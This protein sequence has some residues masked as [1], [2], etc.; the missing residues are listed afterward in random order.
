MNPKANRV[1]PCTYAVKSYLKKARQR[2]PNRP[3]TGNVYDRRMENAGVRD[4]TVFILA[5]GKS[6][7]MGVDKA[8]VEY[9]GRTLLARAL[10]LARLVTPDVSIVGSAEKFA[11]F[12]P[13]VED[14]FRDCGPLGGI[15][16]ALR[17]SLTE[18]NLML[19]V[20]TPFISWAFLQYLISQARGAP[21]AAAV[22][23]RDGEG[24]QPLCAIYRREFA[25]AAENAL[26]AGRN[27]IDL[28]FDTV[29]T[30]VIGQEELESAGFSCA[31][32]RN[33]NTPE[34]L[35]AEKRRA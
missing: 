23:P 1:D 35:E 4:L 28:L 9:D 10:D 17:S 27:R 6:T 33:L 8:F 30:R 18:L 26:R 21:E 3:R 12:A 14:I 2:T 15:D 19:A 29:R 7:R 24:W 25:A 31:L 5:G 22:V 32:F 20:D 13:V 34:E 16:A 11:A